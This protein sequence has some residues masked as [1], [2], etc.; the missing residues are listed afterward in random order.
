ME[1]ESAQRRRLLQFALLGAAAAWLPGCRDDFQP[2]ADLR[3]RFLRDISRLPNPDASMTPFSTYS[4]VALVVNIWAS[5]CPPCVFE[6]P[7]LEKLSTLFH[8]DDL[9]VIGVSAD[10]DLNLLHEFLLSSRITF[11]ILLDRDNE[12]LR[13]PSYPSTFLLRRDHTIAD[14]IVGERDWADTKMVEEIEELLAVR[15]L[16]VTGVM[17]NG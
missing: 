17:G 6:M 10:T 3:G 1:L 2:G 15:R 14:I 7:S 4:G 8:P 11:P 5:W 16:P 9:R 12:I 13:V